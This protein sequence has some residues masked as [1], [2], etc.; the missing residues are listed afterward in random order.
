MSAPEDQESCNAHV[1]QGWSLLS[2][3]LSEKPQR[4]G[5][6]LGRGGSDTTAFLLAEA[7]KVDEIVL[8]TDADGI[9]SEILKL[10][11]IQAPR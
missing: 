5:H 1:E 3:A 8:A 7:L 10:S 2:R 4:Q 6:N 11:Q 9:M